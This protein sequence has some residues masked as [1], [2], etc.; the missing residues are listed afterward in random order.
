MGIPVNSE[1]VEDELLSEEL[2]KE[3]EAAEAEAEPVPVACRPASK[4]GFCMSWSFFGPCFTVSF[5]LLR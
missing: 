3:E 2:L 4:S 1:S 5:N